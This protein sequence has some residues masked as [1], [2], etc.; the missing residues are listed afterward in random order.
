MAPN[1]NK[2]QIISKF[3]FS[4]HVCNYI[5]INLLIDAGFSG[6]G[7]EILFGASVYL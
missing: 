1:F 4:F 2:T 6:E 3:V 7:V 5:L